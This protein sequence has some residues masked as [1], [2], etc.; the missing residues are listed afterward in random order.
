MR[1]YDVNSGS[2]L[3]DGH[4]IKLFRRDALHSL[5]GM[6][7]QDTWLFNGTIADNIR[8]GKL[9]ATDEEVQKAAVAAQVDH[10]VRTLPDGYNMVLNEEADNISQGQKTASD[11][12]PSDFGGPRNPD[13]RRG[14]KLCRYPYRGPDPEG[15]WT[16]S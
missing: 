3:I 1:F 15:Q 16:T 8:Y 5:Y 2:I 13:P 14:D 10:F 6:V 9:G 12:R 11:D 7:L 4:D